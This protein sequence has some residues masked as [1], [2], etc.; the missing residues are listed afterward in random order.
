MYGLFWDARGV[1][2]KVVEVGWK[3]SDIDSSAGGDK[4]DTERRR[5][6]LPIMERLR[7]AKQLFFEIA[8]AAVE[9]APELLRNQLLVDKRLVPV[10][11]LDTVDTTRMEGDSEI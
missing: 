10:L 8:P 7:T 6:E 4:A 3:D 1:E 2:E 9:P 5:L 11:T